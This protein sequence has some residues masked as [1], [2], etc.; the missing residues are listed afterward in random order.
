MGEIESHKETIECPECNHVQEAIV[1]H[2]VPWYS[3]VHICTMCKY[4]IME[5]EWK[6]V[7]WLKKMEME[8]REQFMKDAAKRNPFNTTE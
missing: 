6:V 8:F 7:P 4:I 5:S 2:T 1:E 3:Y